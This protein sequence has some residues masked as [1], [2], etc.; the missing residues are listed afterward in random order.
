MSLIGNNKE[1]FH[2][3]A[4]SGGGYRGLFTAKLIMQI[5]EHTDKLFGSHFDLICGTSIGGVLALALATREITA[6]DMVDKLKE[7]GPKLFKPIQKPGYSDLIDRIVWNKMGFTRERGVFKAKHENIPLQE[8][9]EEIFEDRR[10]SDLKTRILIPTVNWTK[11]GPQFFKTPHHPTFTQD[12]KKRLVDVAMA[13]S[14]APVYLPNYCFD[15][16]IYVDGGLVGNAPGILGVHETE[17]FISS[18]REKD[19]HLLSIGALSSQNTANQSEPLSKGIAQWKGGLFDIMVAC[20]EQTSHYML[21]QKLGTNY[22]M[23][24][25]LL[26]KSQDDVV[27]L[28]KASKAATETLLGIAGNT[29][30]REIARKEL[31]YFLDYQ[32][33]DINFSNPEDDAIK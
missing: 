33:H 4:L 7:V 19:I 16:N 10:I 26:S 21:Q 8:V 18:N 31:Q 11:G 6:R 25:E 15:D 14:A 30:Q 23:I 9:L 27:A 1:P 17:V 32:A 29:F 28:D 12:H 3:L 2:I 5:E 24:D 13:T 20:Q 22:H